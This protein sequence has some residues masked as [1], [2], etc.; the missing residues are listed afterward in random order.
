MATKRDLVEGQEFARR[1]LLTAFTS[2]APAGRE[3]EP[4]K[5]LRGVAA[6]LLLTALLVVGSLAW[7]LLA[8][9]LPD[10]W[11]SGSLVIVKGVGA[12]YV[13]VDGTLYPVLNATSARLVVPSASFHVVQVAADAI[14]DAPRGATIGIVGAPDAPPAADRLVA[15]GWSACVAADGGTRLWVG[16]SAVG[17]APAVVD[18]LGALVEAG[19]DLWLVADGVAHR[20]PVQDRTAV[21]RALGLEQATPVP[22]S[23]AWLTLMGTGTDLEPLVIDGAGDPVP[24]TS[25]LPADVRVG[26]VV[27]VAGAGDVVS[28]Y[29]VDRRGQL[30]PMSDLAAAL[31][32]PGSGAQ[33]GAA[34]QATAAEVA[35]VATATGQAGAADWPAQVPDLPAAGRLPCVTLTTGDEA[36]L[37]M[38][39]VDATA[40]A[41]S[42][43]SVQSGGGAL[44]RAQSAPGAVSVVWLVD[45]AGTAFPVPDASDEVLAR[46]GFAAADVTVVPP[47]WTALF[48]TGPALTTAAAGPPVGAEVSAGTTTPDGAVASDGATDGVTQGATDGASAT[49]TATATAAA[50][51]SAT[52]GRSGLVGD[53]TISV[54]ATVL[55]EGTACSVETPALVATAPAALNVLAA[56]RAWRTSTGAG[57]LVAVVDSGVAA[58]NVHLADAVVPGLDLVGVDVEA[59]GRSDVDGHGTAIAGIV[60][61][62]PVDGS[63]LVG[64]A[65]DA[66][67]LPVRVFYGRTDDAVAAGTGP[68]TA[69]LAAGIVAAADAGAQVINVSLSVSSPDPALEAAVAHATTAGALVVASAGNRTTVDTPDGPRWPAAYDGVLA[70]AA[71]GADGSGTAD[72]IHGPHVLVAAP[73]T[74]VLT[75]YFGAGD[76]VQGATS[77]TSWATAYVSGAAALVAARYPEETPA[78]WAYRLEVTAARLDPAARDDVVGWGVVR[79]DLALAFVDDGT[80]AGP[81]SPSHARPAGVEPVVAQVAG[82]TVARPLAAVQRHATWWALVSVAA[83]L[84]GALALRLVGAGRRSGRHGGPA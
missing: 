82:G 6:G 60:A 68:D 67:I 15:T 34:W 5:P 12:R 56:Q 54:D 62:R 63:G 46:L 19:D 66:S 37:S 30:L 70:V 1:R 58:D 21:I 10:G 81:A 59:S 65:P 35:A 73:G 40:A 33:S 29:V 74:D 43:V 20:I 22:A 53:G 84:S 9:T 50:T 18:G 11:D 77:S 24:A 52:A 69:R 83:V 25:A 8:P 47:A 57:V 4:T 16:A 61:A 75:T 44:V 39:A 2:G 27:E 41:D 48:P 23:G 51:T 64:I 79:P 38:G 42:G 55:A 78:Q 3:L 80:A 7:G 32:A 71:I 31:Y 76:C 28:R 14:E 26:T 45:E 49:A 17:T 72:A 36:V 13:G